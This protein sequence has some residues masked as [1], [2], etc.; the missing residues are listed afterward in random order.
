MSL[1]DMITGGAGNQVAQEGANRF[2][3]SQGQIL[4]LL[5]VAAPMMISYMKKKADN[6][7]SHAEKLDATLTKHHDGSI[8]NNPSQAIERQQ[9]GNSILDHI[10]GG[11]RNQ[12]ENNLSQST[13]IGMDKIGPLLGMLAPVVMG[14]IGSK[15]NPT[16]GGGGIGDLL[17]SILG[18]AS[19][20]I[21][22][23]PTNPLNDILG[24]ILSG[25]QSQGSNPMADILGGLTGNTQSQQTQQ[26][27]GILGN[28]LNGLLK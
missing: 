9:E 14:Y 27:S 2:G 16:T 23:K 10:F 4:A 20:D 26:N 3:V 5:A 8:L 21:Q 15:R 17:G 18:N 11:Q 22:A 28:L 6:D 13:G 19:Q 7:P 1:L 24:G 25:G 12:I